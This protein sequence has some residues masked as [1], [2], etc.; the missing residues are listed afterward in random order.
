MM[1]IR[2]ALELDKMQKF[3]HKYETSHFWW[4]NIGDNNY[5]GFSFYSDKISHR[6]ELKHR[7]RYFC[8]LIETVWFIIVGSSSGIVGS[9]LCGT[10]KQKG[11]LSL[12]SLD[13]ILSSLAATFRLT[14]SL[15]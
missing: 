6:K 2:M 11:E 12:F 10:G 13:L 7:R 1:P 5:I 4:T 9:H 3:N 15:S 8:L 14:L